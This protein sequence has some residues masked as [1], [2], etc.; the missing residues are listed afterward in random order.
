MSLETVRHANTVPSRFIF[1]TALIVSTSVQCDNEECVIPHQHFSTGENHTSSINQNVYLT[2]TLKLTPSFRKTYI[3]RLKSRPSVLDG[4]IPRKSRVVSIG[5]RELREL[6]VETRECGGHDLRGYNAH[7]CGRGTLALSPA[8]TSV[9]PSKTFFVRCRLLSG[10]IEQDET[11]HTT[12]L[13]PTR[14][15]T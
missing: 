6:G 2:P 1:S 14:S 4:Y 7:H 12:S 15:A 5:G 3:L 10:Q 13:T 9:R 8:L 11:A